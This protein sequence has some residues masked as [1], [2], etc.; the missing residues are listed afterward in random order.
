MAKDINQ[1]E[2]KAK[3]KFKKLLLG[4]KTKILYNAVF[5][6]TMKN[7]RYQA[8]KSRKSNYWCKSQTIILQN[9]FQKIY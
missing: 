5:G 6:K 7:I 9:S 3:K 1:Y 8:C 2:Y 4:K